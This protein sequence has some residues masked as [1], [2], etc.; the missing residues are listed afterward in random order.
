VVCQ[1]DV[2]TTIDLQSIFDVDKTVGKRLVFKL[3][4]LTAIEFGFESEQ[5]LCPECHTILKKIYQLE[6]MIV[7]KVEKNVK[8]KVGKKNINKY[9]ELYEK[10]E[11]KKEVLETNEGIT[12]VGNVL[13]EFKEEI[14]DLNEEI[15]DLGNV[16]N[17]VKDNHDPERD[18]QNILPNNESEM[19]N[20]DCDI[21]EGGKAASLAFNDDL[22][23]KSKSILKKPQIQISGK[24][25]NLK[26]NYEKGIVTIGNPYNQ[27]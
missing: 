10:G 4:Q 11:A 20:E 17:K 3:H 9:Q 23:R 21:T 26:N 13:N 12:E 6:K 14:L 19:E 16:C 8:H 15:S 7:D 2:S 25:Q 27:S 24:T 5:N 18:T 22:L 1:S